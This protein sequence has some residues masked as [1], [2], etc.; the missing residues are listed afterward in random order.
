MTEERITKAQA[1]VVVYIKENPYCDID[2]I[3]YGLGIKKNA[4][5]AMLHKLEDNEIIEFS[6]EPHSGIATSYGN[7]GWIIV[8]SKQNNLKVK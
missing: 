8:Q 5:S 3:V 1:I 7:S 2:N 4:V 6:H